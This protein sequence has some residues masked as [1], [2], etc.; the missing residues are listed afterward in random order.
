MWQATIDIF[1]EYLFVMTWCLEYKN[2]ILEYTTWRAVFHRSGPNK[3][4]NKHF[5]Y[6]FFWI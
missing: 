3:H 1:F 6:S 2:A 5:T 4:R